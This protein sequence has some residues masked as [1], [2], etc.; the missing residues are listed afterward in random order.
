[1]AEVSARLFWRVL[2]FLFVGRWTPDQA[3]LALLVKETQFRPSGRCGWAWPGLLLL[4][5]VSACGCVTV[6]AA[7]RLSQ[8]LRTPCSVWQGPSRCCPPAHPGHFGVLALRGGGP[9]KGPEGPSRGGARRGGGAGGAGS[10]RASAAAGTSQEA[11]RGRKQQG[12]GSQAHAA[13]AGADIKASCMV[14]ECEASTERHE[15]LITCLQ[16]KRGYVYT[17][18]IDGTLRVWDALSGNC[19]QVL[20]RVVEGSEEAVGYVASLVCGHARMHTHPHGCTRI[21]A[22]AYL[23]ALVH[24]HREVVRE[25]ESGREQA[26]MRESGRGKRCVGREGGREASTWTMTR[27]HVHYDTHTQPSTSTITRAST[28][29]ITSCASTITPPE[30]LNPKH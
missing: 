12:G 3:M 10:R 6:H 1:M 25:C 11:S 19:I 29:T 16:Y 18:S 17:G 27:E 20:Q 8:P 4:G 15:A 24:A 2:F 9:P 14:L 30:T 13:D 21:L 23:L 22:C 5:C 7:G 26:R 28:S